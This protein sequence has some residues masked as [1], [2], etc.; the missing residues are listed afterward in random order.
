MPLALDSLAFAIMAGNIELVSK[1]LYEMQHSAKVARLDLTGIYPYHLA[2]SFLD[3]GRT[4]CL[5]L[6]ELTLELQGYHY[7]IALNNVDSNEHTVLDCLMISVLRSHTNLSPA[8]VSTSFVRCNRFPGEEKDICGRWDANSPGLRQL[9]KSGEVKIPDDWKHNFCHS[10]VQAVC[11]STMAIFLPSSRPDVNAVSGLFRR[12]CTS[13]GLEMK[14]GPLHTIVAVAFHL[15]ENGKTG[16]T[17]FGPL[18]CLVC[19]LVLGADAAQVADLSVLDIFSSPDEGTCRHRPMT[20]VELTEQVPEE[21]RDEWRSSVKVGWRCLLLVLCH[22]TAWSAAPEREKQFMKFSKTSDL[23]YQLYDDEEMHGIDEDE[24]YYDAG[25]C[26]WKGCPLAE[27]DYTGL[28]HVKRDLGVLWAT[29]Q[30][31]LLTYRKV[32]T[33]DADISEHFQLSSLL[34]WLEEK[35]DTFETPLLTNGMMKYHATCGWFQGEQNSF[36][37][38]ASHVCSKYFMNM[39]IWS[40]ASFVADM[41]IESMG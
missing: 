7:L 39:D 12:R 38:T 32:D 29:I 16:E 2:A 15:A 26:E 3:G 22:T 21:V 37:V 8:E 14:L 9:Y 28:P 18:A 23:S 36:V 27:H 4:C 31:E 41:A 33:A 1:I 34:S 13:C 11:H 25:D 35:S 40:R 19:L 30:T 5:M 24:R 6:N 17:L 10:S 20:A